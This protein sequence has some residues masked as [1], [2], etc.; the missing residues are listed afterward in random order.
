MQREILRK[1]ALLQVYIHIRKGVN[2]EIKPPGDARQLKLLMALW[3][4]AN[5]W[6]K[7]NNYQTW[8]V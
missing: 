1:I 8:Q 5:E 7:S 6:M 3:Q 2:I 4:V